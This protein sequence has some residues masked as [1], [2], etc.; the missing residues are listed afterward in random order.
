MDFYTK[1]GDYYDQ[2]FPYNPAQLEFVKKNLGS[3]K[4]KHLLD[5]GCG[6]GALSFKLAELD[7]E[8]I[9]AIDYDS[10]MVEKAKAKKS[11]REHLPVFYEMDMREIAN[12]FEPE[13]FDAVICFGNTLVHLLTHSEIDQ[14][15]ESVAKILKKSGSFMLQIL[16]YDH[17]LNKKIGQLPVIEN[18]EI[19]FERFYNF[20]TDNL[21]DFRTN[22]AVK[23]EDLSIDNVIQLNPIRGN[24]ILKLL[25]NHNFKLI[26]L[27]GDFKMNPLKEDSLPFVVHAV[28]R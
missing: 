23:N 14:F 4:N 7:F 28:K 13:S 10:K 11:S 27:Y 24:A 26:R 22:L 3:V 1:I 2:I 6:T 18:E 20:R 9:H 12:H 17:I 19:R 5:I 25:E 15:I 21:I 8:S 16:N